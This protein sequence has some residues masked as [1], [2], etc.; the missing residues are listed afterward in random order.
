[1]VVQQI[2]NAYRDKKE[3]PCP[4]T[5]RLIKAGYQQEYGGYIKFAKENEIVVDYRK[6]FPSQWWHL[7]ESYCNRTKLQQTFG[8][9]IGC[10]E[11]I[12]WMAEVLKCVDNK[13]LNSLANEI[14]Q[15]GVLVKRR[16]LAKPTTTFCRKKWN[17]EIQKLCFDR[18]K[19]KVER[20]F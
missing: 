1:M 3:C 19:E 18:I 12:F 14:I 10:G 7:I 9:N 5:E 15:S 13:E 16:N 4:I 17:L 11:L 8:K 20:L 2:L 6:G